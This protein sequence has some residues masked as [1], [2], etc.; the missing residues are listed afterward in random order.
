[1]SLRD[2]D[3]LVDIGLLVARVGLG[4]M[5]MV[6]GWPKITGGP[7]K[8]RGLGGAMKHL[9]IDFLPTMWG[10]LAAFAEFGGGLLLALG[11]FARPAAAMLVF[12]MVVAARLHFAKGDGLSGASHAIELG[13]AMLALLIAGPGKYALE[14]RRRTRD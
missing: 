13:I 12:T 2:R 7:D 6:H 1:M 11:V 9:G 10:F 5:L 8:W 3:D 14:I 4:A